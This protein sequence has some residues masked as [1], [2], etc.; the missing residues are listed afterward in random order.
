MLVDFRLLVDPVMWA[1]FKSKFRLQSFNKKK[2][3]MYI[4]LKSYL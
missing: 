2:I 4:C 1:I 3:K